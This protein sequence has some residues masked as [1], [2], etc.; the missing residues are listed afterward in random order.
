[1]KL[2]YFAVFA[3][4]L[5][6]IVQGCSPPEGEWKEPELEEKLS[7]GE[8]LM[9]GKVVKHY[10]HPMEFEEQA[11][12]AEMEVYCWYK[13]EATPKVVN[14]SDAGYINGHCA[15]NDLDIGKE[16]YAV[17][18]HQE[19]EGQKLP[20]FTPAHVQYINESKEALDELIKVCGLQVV[21]PIGQ[22]SNAACPTPSSNT[23]APKVIQANVTVG[24]GG[25]TSEPPVS[26]GV[27]ATTCF[28]MTSLFALMVIVCM[29]MYK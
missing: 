17:L 1:M 6:A 29:V 22:T 15:S 11:Y 12:I 7:W 10:P 24:G 4:V 28:E 8:W 18:Y 25:T 19:V 9:Y 23:C 14:I 21:L 27:R 26:F 5:G 20:E 2:V 16:Y 3:S 13:G